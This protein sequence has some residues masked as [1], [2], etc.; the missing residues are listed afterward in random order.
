MR[1]TGIHGEDTGLKLRMR[2]TG[3]QQHLPSIFSDMKFLKPAIEI[4]VHLVSVLFWMDLVGRV[5]ILSF[6]S[7]ASDLLGLKHFV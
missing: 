2:T 6:V 7:A 3:T 1:I 4:L 5:I